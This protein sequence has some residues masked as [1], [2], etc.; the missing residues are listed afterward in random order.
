MQETKKVGYAVL[1][2][3]VGKSHARAVLSSKN[4]K[5]VAV[6]DLLEEKLEKAKEDYGDILTYTDFELMLKNPDIE[7]I[8]NCLP[9]AM[10]ADFTVRA[11]EAGKHVLVEK[12]VDIT[13]QA[14]EKI[15]AARKKTGL[16][17][18]VIHQN[19]FNACMTPV[20]EAIDSG[21]LGKLILGTFAVKWYRTQ[22]YYDNGGW[23]GTWDM[24]G[25]G[26]LMNQAIHTVDL[27]Q[28]L[29]GDVESVTSHM[30]VF[31]HDIET[32]DMTAS[33][34]KFK[35]GSSATF[36]STTCAYPGISTDVQVYGSKGSIEVNEDKLKLWAFLD[37]DE[38]ESKKMLDKYGAGNGSLTSLDPGLV[39][40]HA[41]Q[42]HDIIDAVL[43][44]KEPLITP[45]DAIKSV[46]IANAIY[47]SARSGKTIY[48]E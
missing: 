26:S 32:E 13:V 30:G 25:G 43:F 20:K 34:I 39:V 22:E 12:P 42:V 8:S 41:T 11:L 7:I 47:D 46:A 16:K 33:L 45:N 1:G 21:K 28:W 17:V 18:G 6:C 29:M 4:G 35:N 40:G 23:R 37:E 36:V 19:R 15:E 38:E 10:H 9:S 27:M 48:F 3:G 5:L 14:A 44:D 2:L 24:D 31:A